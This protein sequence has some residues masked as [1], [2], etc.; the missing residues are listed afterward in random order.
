MRKRYTEL[1]RDIKIEG[2][3]DFA[4]VPFVSILQA[5]YVLLCEIALKVTLLT[6]ELKIKISTSAVIFNFIMLCCLTVAG[7][8]RNE[9]SLFN[10]T[11]SIVPM[12]TALI[13]NI[14]INIVIIKCGEDYIDYNNLD[15]SKTNIFDE[16]VLDEKQ[17]IN[18]KSRTNSPDI[19]I[20]EVPLSSH[21]VDLE[22]AS[23]IEVKPNN[24]TEQNKSL[25]DLFEEEFQDFDD[26]EIDSYSKV[27]IPTLDFSDISTDMFPDISVGS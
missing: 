22:I 10:G 5:P 7:V 1:D 18:P 24:V 25:S 12:A 16:T 13:I 20:N 11:N 14:I 3:A 27:G 4:R 2:P 21:G 8:M 19:K 26:M 9:V 6:R 17:K 23:D 15:E